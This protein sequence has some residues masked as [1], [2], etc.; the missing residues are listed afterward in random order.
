[1]T[2]FELAARSPCDDAGCSDGCGTIDGAAVCTCPGNL[3][4]GE[5]MATCISEML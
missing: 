4:L 2:L 1:M 3:V 5:D